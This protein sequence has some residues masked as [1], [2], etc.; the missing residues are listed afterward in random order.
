MKII[1]HKLGKPAHDP[2]TE[3]AQMYQTRMHKYFATESQIL[4]LTEK[5]TERAP[6]ILMQ[7][8]R[9][10]SVRHLVICLD[11]RGESFDTKTLANKLKNWT[12][13]RTIHTI[14]FVVGGPYG[15]D[16]AS[17]KLADVRWSLS[18]LT[19]QGDLAW[20]T[21]W[22]QLYRAASFLAGHPYHHD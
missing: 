19:F 8:F 6:Q 18:K 9:N 14:H 17:L 20:V 13:D 22:E 2:Y 4:K 15:F 11:E 16:E 10:Q 12:E 7:S 1:V 3:L 21:L 5:N